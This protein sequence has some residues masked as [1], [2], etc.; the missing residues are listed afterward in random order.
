MAARLILLGRLADLAGTPELAV[1]LGDAAQ[2]DW[3]GL[4]ALL[5][6]ALAEAATGPKI[7]LALNGAVLADKTT[8]IARSGDELALLPPVSG[9]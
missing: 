4:L 5:P 3:P 8:L 9:G 1:P 6:A 2:I 7:R